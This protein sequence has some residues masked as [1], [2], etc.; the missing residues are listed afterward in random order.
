MGISRE[1]ENNL[2]KGPWS[3]AHG[4]TGLVGFFSFHQCQVD[5]IFRAVMILKIKGGGVSKAPIGTWGRAPI[6][7]SFLT[8]SKLFRAGYWRLY[9][10]GGVAGA[11]FCCVQPHLPI[12]SPAPVRFAVFGSGGNILCHGLC[13]VG[14]RGIPGRAAA[15]CQCVGTGLGDRTTIPVSPGA[16]E[17][18]PLCPVTAWGQ[19]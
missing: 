2:I 17:E 8:N 13:G 11:V 15:L 12:A 19:P 9:K 4:E 14:G 10:V 18:P 7:C 3:Q 1:K 6:S 5:F 16:P